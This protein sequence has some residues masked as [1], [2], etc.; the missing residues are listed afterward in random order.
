MHLPGLIPMIDWLIL[1]MSLVRDSKPDR[2]QRSAPDPV[3]PRKPAALA[4]FTQQR[5]RLVPLIL[6]LMQECVRRKSA[7]QLAERHAVDIV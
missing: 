4:L 1:L 6:P 5:Q 7:L 3:T 2:C